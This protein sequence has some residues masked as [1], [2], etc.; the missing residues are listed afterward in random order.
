MKTKLKPVGTVFE[1]VYPPI[2]GDTNTKASIIKYQVIAYERAARFDDDTE[3][4][5]REVVEAIDIRLVDE[6]KI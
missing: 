3:G 4:V 1:V 6:D 5:R 2:I